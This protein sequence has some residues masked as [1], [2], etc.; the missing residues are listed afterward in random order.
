MSA[1]KENL[2]GQS[3][4]SLRSL[5]HR[6]EL[7]IMSQL[8]SISGVENERGVV[9]SEISSLKK[10]LSQLHSLQIKQRLEKFELVSLLYPRFM[11]SKYEGGTS[12]SIL[13]LFINK[14]RPRHEVVRDCERNSVSRETPV[15]YSL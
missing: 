2:V 4:K 12:T 10:E 13:L 8:K 14:T 3:R 11:L 7:L 9:D 1:D 15:L 6:K 5:Q